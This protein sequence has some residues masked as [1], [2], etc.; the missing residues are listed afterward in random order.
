MMWKQ[1]FGLVG[2]SR[3]VVEP[4]G[5]S[6]ECSHQEAHG[7]WRENVTGIKRW[8]A[9]KGFLAVYIPWVMRNL[10]VNA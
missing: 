2:C 6:P 8:L 7:K 5:D 10:E 4:F 9:E 1:L 3:G